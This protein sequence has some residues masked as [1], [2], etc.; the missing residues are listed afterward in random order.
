[1][2]MWKWDSSSIINND[3]IATFDIYFLYFLLWWLPYKRIRTK[4][5]NR[6]DANKSCSQFSPMNKYY[7]LSLSKFT[8]HTERVIPVQ[9]PATMR[10]SGV[11]MIFLLVTIVTCE[12]TNAL[13]SSD[14]PPG[15]T[16]VTS[17]GLGCLLFNR[18]VNIHIFT[19][20][21]IRCLLLS[22][23]DVRS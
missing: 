21:S 19:Y 10:S 23:L 16:D 22:T 1:M 20:Y 13:T 12:D 7:F 8:I 2:D 9:E 6:Y 11:Y 4:H 17:E 14:C 3:M 5:S 15:W 18:S